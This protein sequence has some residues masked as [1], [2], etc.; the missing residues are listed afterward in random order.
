VND[1]TN[2]FFFF[3][4]PYRDSFADYGNGFGDDNLI[5]LID[6][7]DRQEKVFLANRADDDWFDGKCKSLNTHYFDITYTAGRR[8]KTEDGYSAKK[9]TE[10]LLYKTGDFKHKDIMPLAELAQAPTQEALDAL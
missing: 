6:F 5:K 2:G 9:A 10:I 8:K 3:D 4:P 1:D 7:C